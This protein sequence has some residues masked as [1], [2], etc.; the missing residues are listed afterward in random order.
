MSRVRL[1]IMR[2][3]YGWYGAIEDKREPLRGAPLGPVS[4]RVACAV[5]FACAFSLAGLG[6]V[7]ARMV[8]PELPPLAGTVRS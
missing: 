3:D 5:A 2:T 6:L 1:A 4:D 7:A 8:V